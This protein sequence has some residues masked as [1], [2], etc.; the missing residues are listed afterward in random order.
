[1]YTQIITYSRDGDRSLPSRLRLFAFGARDGRRKPWRSTDFTGHNLCFVLCR[2]MP[3]VTVEIH[4]AIVIPNG[5][6]V[7]G[8]FS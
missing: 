4:H 8:G 2:N 1:M 3:G 7:A 6:D 5:Y